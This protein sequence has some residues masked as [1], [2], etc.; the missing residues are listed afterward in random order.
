MRIVKLPV[1]VVDERELNERYI[2]VL[3]GHHKIE[4]L[5]HN[6]GYVNEILY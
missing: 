3:G 1:G 5:D 6:M 4:Y 2:V